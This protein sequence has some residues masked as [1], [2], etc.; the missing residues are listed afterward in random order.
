MGWTAAGAGAP[1]ATGKP[2]VVAGSDGAAYV[3]IR[4]TDLGMWI[5]RVQ[6]DVWGQWYNGQGSLG[7]D[8]DLAAAGGIVYAAVTGPT[9]YVYVRP[10]LEGAG[11]G[12]QNWITAGGQ[13]ER[14]TIAVGGGRF[15][16]AGK[17]VGNVL[18]WYAS[19]AGWTS[20][21]PAGTGAGN[22]AAGPK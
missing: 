21:G 8:P 17:T 2:A 6:G 20:L 12:W 9:G 5:V 10:F 3:A 7:A 1:L 22:L 11:A 14:V 16:L 18:W 19:G 15:F 4:A 13:L